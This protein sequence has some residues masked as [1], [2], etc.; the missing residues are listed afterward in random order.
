MEIKLIAFDLDGTLLNDNKEV[1]EEN[2]RALMDAAERGIE[3]VPATGRLPGVMPEALRGLPIRYAIFVNGAEVV[4]LQTGEVIS[5]TLIP[6]QKAIEVFQE[7]EQYPIAYDC[8][9][10]NF[11][12]MSQK[13]YDR[14]PEFIISPHFVKMVYETR[15]AVP[16]LKAFLAQEKKDVQKLLFYFREDQ[17]QLR[18]ELLLN[19]KIPGIEV[20]SSFPGNLELNHAEG[21]KGPALKRLADHLGIPME[22]TMAFGDGHNDLSMISMAGFGVAMEECWPGVREVADYVTCSCN[23]SGV[24]KAI[25]KFCLD[26]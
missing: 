2:F 17:Q 8:Y 23:D 11:G 25:R 21:I 20:S 5:R 22:Q 3:I 9:M 15:H 24:A 1:S 4:D 7:G 13:F 10:E 12:Y 26:N 14:I 18:E 6:W 16:E 19:W